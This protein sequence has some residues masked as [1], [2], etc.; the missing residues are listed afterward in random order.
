MQLS[1]IETQ[2]HPAAIVLAGIALSFLSALAPTEAHAIQL[3]PLQVAAGLLPYAVFGMIAA[4]LRTP[5]VTRIGLVILAA[6]AAAAVLQRGL[7]P[8]HGSGPLLV[9]V[10]ILA[11][12]AL[13]A[14][15][16][17]AVRDSAIPS[18]KPA[19]IPEKSG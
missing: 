16:P 5:V 2:V 12:I 9:A 13:M 7:S 18:G 6:H 11:A 19:S 17:R 10:P 1:K 3:L 4:M 15:W 14:L 8:D